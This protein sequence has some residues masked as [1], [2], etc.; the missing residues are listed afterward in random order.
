MKRNLILF[1]LF[2]LFA[3]ANAQNEFAATGFYKEFKKIYADAQDGFKDCKASQRKTGFE[4]IATEYRSKCNLPIADSGKIV[5]PLAANPYAIYYFQPDKSRLKVDQQG[6]YL[7][8]ALVYA[9]EKPLYSRTE[10]FLVNEKPFTN[11]YYFTEP[12]E[13]KGSAALFRQCIYYQDGKYMMSFEFKGK[14]PKVD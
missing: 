10:T 12:E 14:M 13:S 11:T 2:F 6:V 8:E 9:F 3:S 5:F 1:Q 4:A 7:R